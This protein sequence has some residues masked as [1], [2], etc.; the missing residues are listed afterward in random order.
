MNPL[1]S[2]I[3]PVYNGMPYWKEYLESVLQQTFRPLEFICIDDGS[4]DGSFEYLEMMRPV[5]EEKGIL[6]IHKKISHAGQAAAVQEALKFVTGEFIT[7]CDADD[8]MFPGNIEKKAVFLMQ[9]PELGMVRNDGVSTENGGENV[10]VTN[11]EDRKQQNIFDALFHDT[12]YCYA[13]CYMIRSTLFFQCYPERKIP[14]SEEGQNLQLLLPAAS[15]TECGFIPEVLHIYRRHPEG[16]SS[17]KRSFL[18]VKKRIENFTALK[19][20]LLPYCRCERAFYEEEAKRI[21]KERKQNLMNLAAQKARE[22]RNYENRHSD[23][24]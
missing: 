23:L 9:H 3:T 6:L 10:P 13:G 11:P 5:F 4:E 16:H 7:W 15:R 17:K 2:L 21:E 18:Q 14:V 8:I 1:V 24:S 20:E 22:E 12:T 19:M